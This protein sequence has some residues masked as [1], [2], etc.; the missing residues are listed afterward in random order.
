MINK[1]EYRSGQKVIAEKTNAPSNQQE[2]ESTAASFQNL[3][4]ALLFIV[5]AAAWIG[6]DYTTGQLYQAQILPACFI[7]SCLLLFK[8]SSR[9]FSPYPFSLNQ[10]RKFNFSC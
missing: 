7:L 2:S 1:T 10:G 8:A 6:L 3:A 5:I 4:P 9:W